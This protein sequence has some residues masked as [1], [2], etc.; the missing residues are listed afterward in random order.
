MEFMDM[1]ILAVSVIKFWFPN[2]YAVVYYLKLLTPLLKVCSVNLPQLLSLA[3]RL[4][5]AV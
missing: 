4:G 1:K 5:M 2:Y 3:V